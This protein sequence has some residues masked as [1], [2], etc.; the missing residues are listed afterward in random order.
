MIVYEE[1]T[2]TAVKT[3]VSVDK[4]FCDKCGREIQDGIAFRV[5]FFPYKTGFV[6]EYDLYMSGVVNYEYKADLCNSCNEQIVGLL[7]SIKVKF[8]KDKVDRHNQDNNMTSHGWKPVNCWK[9][10]FWADFKSPY[11][12][13]GL[14]WIKAVWCFD[15]FDRCIDIEF[16]PT[17]K[18]LFEWSKKDDN[19]L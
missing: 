17:G 9:L 5:E 14:G 6:D 11:K 8:E 2:K 19:D 10:F 13:V 18:T 4:I 7:E 1:T 16:M 15:D 12:S 3:E